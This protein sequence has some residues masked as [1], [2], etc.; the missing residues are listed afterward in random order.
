[1][2]VLE[3]TCRCPEDSLPPAGG[4]EDT[5]T[6]SPA[7]HQPTEVLNTEGAISDQTDLLTKWIPPNDFISP[8]MEQ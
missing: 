2:H 1:M 4:P 7:F 6:P 5:P 3:A 8:Y